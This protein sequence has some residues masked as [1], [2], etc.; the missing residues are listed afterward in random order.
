MRIQHLLHLVVG[1][2]VFLRHEHNHDERGLSQ[3]A[4]NAILLTGAVTIA[5]V[6]ITLLGTYVARHLPK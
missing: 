2:A 3:S 1:L 5:G 6:V 4:E